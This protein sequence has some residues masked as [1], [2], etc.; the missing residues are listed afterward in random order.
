EQNRV[1]M[2]RL[3]LPVLLHQR[4]RRG[5]GH[6]SS[7]PTT[8]TIELDLARESIRR[9]ASSASARV[10]YRP[11]RTRN[12]LAVPTTRASRPWPRSFVASCSA[13]RFV[14]YAAIC[15]VNAPVRRGAD[16]VSAAGFGSGFVVVSTP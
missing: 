9:D 13:A 11:T 2:T 10:A 15:T 6:R 16:V 8:T 3:D 1:L 14:S 5:H 7:G 4:G 12:G